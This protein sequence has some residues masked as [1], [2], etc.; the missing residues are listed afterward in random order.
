M[1]F[2]KNITTSDKTPP[3]DQVDT[4]D[5]P[6]QTPMEE[7][8]ASCN[9]VSST[10][11][12]T[13]S[14]FPD[15]FFSIQSSEASLGDPLQQIHSDLTAHTNVLRSE[16][17]EFVKSDF[18]DSNNDNH[19]ISV[20][21][22]DEEDDLNSDPFDQLNIVRVSVPKLDNKNRMIDMPMRKSRAKKFKSIMDVCEDRDP[23][24]EDLDVF[25]KTME[26]VNKLDQLRDEFHMTEPSHPPLYP[27]EIQQESLPDFHD[28][29]SVP[30]LDEL[31]FNDPPE[32]ASC[33]YKPL[34]SSAEHLE[35]DNASVDGTRGSLTSSQEGPDLR[36]LTL[37]S[38]W[39]SMVKS[40]Q[41][42]VIDP[43]R[44][45]ISGLV[46]SHDY[47]KSIM[48]QHS[49]FMG[50][51]KA[52][53]YLTLWPLMKIYSKLGRDLLK[54]GNQWI[55]EA[56]TILFASDQ[57][58]Y[59]PSKI[60]SKNAVM[61]ENFNI[62]ARKHNLNEHEAFRIFGG[63]YLPILDYDSPLLH[64]LFIFYH[65]SRSPL[66]TMRPVHIGHLS[67][68]A[69]LHSG[70][71]GATTISI[72]R[73]I[74]NQIQKCII[75]RRSTPLLYNIHHGTSYGGL[76]GE[77]PLF[78]HTFIDP[79]FSINIQAMP[80]PDGVVKLPI[81]ILVCG[82]SYTVE[83]ELLHN[84]QRV[85]IQRALI[86]FQTRTGFIIRKVTADAAQVFQFRDKF[87]LKGVP[88]QTLTIRS[89][90][91]NMAEKKMYLVRRYVQMVFHVSS[92]EVIRKLVSFTDAL[93]ILHMM[94]NAI[95]MVPYSSFLSHQGI[96][97]DHLRRPTKYLKGLEA[98][99]K[100]QSKLE[101]SMD[102]A[103]FHIQK[104]YDYFVETRNKLVQARADRFQQREKISSSDIEP[105]V[106]DIAFF[107]DP[108]H[109][110]AVLCRI[111]HLSA[112]KA[113]VFLCDT[114]IHKIIPLSTLHVLINERPENEEKDMDMGPFILN[115]DHEDSQS[116]Q[117]CQESRITE[118]DTTS[119]VTQNSE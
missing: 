105:R 90:W 33:S 78:S 55:I 86:N 62:L 48:N 66:H 53:S 27:P 95:N 89:Q 18:G 56:S 65:Q 91:Q 49:T 63:F 34:M 79:I 118:V 21:L 72:T 47:Y 40:T 45:A 54:E 60:N 104:I 51:L 30:S 106:G 31:N 69:A 58:H 5:T 38:T 15:K 41:R 93:A 83:F 59:P 25:K 64:T 46:L 1:I 67:T 100:D 84:S 12:T 115:E 39:Y 98:S 92:Q 16:F 28:P 35:E 112:A 8:M 14:V 119:D 2:P 107:V 75:C 85:S 32:E 81:L 103:W 44:P 96:S 114:L 50:K 94:A 88:I 10:P 82:H 110:K 77:E 113:T 71:F 19:G 29:P 9:F 17:E 6:H 57:T 42:H 13:Q 22:S 26:N 3:S 23:L 99:E 4:S 36:E 52:V 73:W 102:T 76:G 11:L 87:I 74:R 111:T 116:E 70:P 117:S 20:D 37:L 24:L 61:V 109:K 80:G 101:N 7:D 68:A 43:L 108:L 97:P